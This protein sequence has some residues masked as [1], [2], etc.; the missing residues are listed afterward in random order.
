[1]LKKG[2][3]KIKYRTKIKSPSDKWIIPYHLDNKKQRRTIKK[4]LKNE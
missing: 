4:K 1:M 3:K 2:L